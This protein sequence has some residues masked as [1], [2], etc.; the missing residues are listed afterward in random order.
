MNGVKMNEYVEPLNN[1][2]IMGGGYAGANEVNKMRDLL[3]ILGNPADQS[4]IGSPPQR[5][6]RQQMNHQPQQRRIQQPQH[7]NYQ[8]NGYIPS[9]NEVGLNESTNYDNYMINNYDSNYDF[10]PEPQ[11]HQPIQQ[12]KHPIREDVSFIDNKNAK[13]SVE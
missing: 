10:S 11:Y 9:M 13:S 5:V 8:N 7:N 3:S 6:Q 12:Y 1:G 2:P 4:D